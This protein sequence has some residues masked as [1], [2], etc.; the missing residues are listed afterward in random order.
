M[1]AILEKLSRY[2]LYMKKEIFWEMI[3][4]SL[5]L[6]QGICETLEQS[7][8]PV[9]SGMV[10]LTQILYFYRKMLKTNRTL[11]PLK[12]KKI[13]QRW[14]IEWIAKLW[15][16]RQQMFKLQILLLF[17]EILRVI[18]IRNP[19]T[20]PSNKRIWLKQILQSYNKNRKVLRIFSNKHIKRRKGEH[21]KF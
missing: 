8:R 2:W 1:R 15:A 6:M 13:M 7:P 16:Q 18:R 5:I 10:N 4:R 20:H 19:W 11:Y 3:R 9:I 14:I 17:K 12:L 21:K